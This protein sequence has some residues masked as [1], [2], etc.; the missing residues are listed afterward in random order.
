MVIVAALAT[1]RLLVQAQREC[2]LIRL[3]R[4]DDVSGIVAE[5]QMNDAL[6]GGGGSA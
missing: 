1:H 6:A 4:A 2:E 5:K 3:R